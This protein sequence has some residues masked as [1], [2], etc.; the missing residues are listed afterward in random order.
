LV[1]KSAFM[2]EVVWVSY[3]IRELSKRITPFYASPIIGILWTVWWLP[4]VSFNAGI[5]DNLPIWSLTLNMLGAA[6]M[7]AIVYG[8]TKSGIC[9]CLLQFMMNMSVLMLPVSPAVGG[10]QTY[11]TYAVIYFIAMLGITYFV[12]PTKNPTAI[13]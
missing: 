9:V 4:S 1:L 7:C 6:G 10:I 11:S 2:G 3:A 8:K 5:I 12:N 13:K